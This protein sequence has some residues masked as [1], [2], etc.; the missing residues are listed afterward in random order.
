[1]STTCKKGTSILPGTIFPAIPG[2][3]TVFL[4]LTLHF[5]P[6]L[7]KIWLFHLNENYIFEIS[8]NSAIRQ[9]ICPKI[10]LRCFA[11]NI[12]LSVLMKY[13]FQSNFDFGGNSKTA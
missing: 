3:M 12:L 11:D 8:D 6:S 4:V 13:Y 1:M 10:C 7:P 2:K 9:K 5:H